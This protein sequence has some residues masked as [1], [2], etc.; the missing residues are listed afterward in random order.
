MAHV[1][2]FLI[3]ESWGPFSEEK[4]L[5]NELISSSIDMRRVKHFKLKNQVELAKET[6]F[7]YSLLPRQ[8]THGLKLNKS[9]QNKEAMG[10]EA[11]FLVN[12]WV[13]N[14]ASQI[15]RHPSSYELRKRNV[16]GQKWQNKYSKLH[17]EILLS[18]RERKFIV[19]SC[20]EKGY[21]CAGYGNRLG[22][23]TSL[24]FLSV[25]T[26]R[27]FLIEWGRGVP[28]DFYLHP[29]GIEWNYSV[30]NLKD[31]TT[32]KHYWGKRNQLR[33]TRS[34]F[35]KTPDVHADF[36]RW[37]RQTDFRNYFDRPVE[38]VTGVWY[39]ASHLWKHDFL[40]KLAHAL[41]IN[42][43]RSQ[44]SLIG[45]AFDFLFKK[46]MELETTLD[47]ARRSLALTNAVPKL[48]LHI[49]MGDISF[50]RK[51]HLNTIHFERFFTC[52]R[53]LGDALARKMPEFT[54]RNVKWFLATDDIEI[55]MH[56]L[57]KYPENVVTLNVT[58]V[59]ITQLRRRDS[60]SISGMYGVLMDHLILSE[61]DFLILSKSTFGNTAVGL[62]FHSNDTYTN[63]E[64]CGEAL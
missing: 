7:P 40:S 43:Q 9:Y 55:K 46:S 18:Q 52:A 56:A 10:E 31:L 37:F 15:R 30:A 27:A 12:K 25:L 48:G 47:T 24:L 63:G 32:R 17:R 64:K 49:R 38:K 35:E 28:L 39:F 3:S 41:G 36:I 51:I 16:C 6:S 60:Q 58:P 33:P 22:A 23:I 21:G 44:Y 13:E 11:S 53:A 54:K 42:S 19:Y 8:V 1:F 62:G 14:M 50:G 26:Q 20:K 5:T 59:H 2:L 34:D 57:Q 29:K 45:C 61:C 4:A